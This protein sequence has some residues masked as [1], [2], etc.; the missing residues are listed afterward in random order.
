M[1][2]IPRILVVGYLISSVFLLNSGELRNDQWKGSVTKDKGVE[3][4]K[5]PKEPLFKETNSGFE[6]ELTIRESESTNTFSFARLASLL[7]DADGNI[8]ALDARES[9]IKVFSARG[10]FLRT[11]GRQGNGPGELV[12]PVYMDLFNSTELA[13]LD[14]QSRRLT[15]FGLNGEYR[16]SVST[17]RISMGEMKTDSAGNIYSMVLAIK[18][19]LRRHELQKFDSNLNYLK[20][21]D[22]MN[23]REDRNLTLFV[24]GPHFTIA[25]DG[26]IWYGCP[27]SEY[28]LKGYTNEGILVKKIQKIYIPTRIPKAELEMQT[29]GVPQGFEVYI[30]DFYSPY[31]DIEDDDNGRIIVLACML[32]KENAYFFDVFNS[33]G[34]YIETKQFRPGHRASRFR[35][36]KDRLYVV[37]EEESGLSVIK[38]Y[39]IKWA[40]S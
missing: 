39:R 2:D 27:E 21:F 38:V 24:A 37:E 8:Y 25:E 29:R 36:N 16:R 33:E 12:T 18:D 3:V 4:I 17:A 20:T 1:L 30:P 34:R 5:N 28:E 26:L 14:A 13:V 31:Y 9:N 10:Q 35:W 19:D 7:V 40:E 6:L 23:I 32:S 11:I 22:F 15:F